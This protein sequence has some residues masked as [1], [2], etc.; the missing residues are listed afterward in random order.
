MNSSFQLLKGETNGEKSKIPQLNTN[1]FS[2]EKL[3]H[4]IQKKEN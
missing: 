1:Y 3:P 2:R 4:H